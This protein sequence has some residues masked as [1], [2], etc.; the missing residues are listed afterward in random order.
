MPDDDQMPSTS[1]PWRPANIRESFLA[2]V[3]R[4]GSQD[5]PTEIVE[6][7]RTALDMIAQAAPNATNG[8][9]IV[10]NRNILN[11][12]DTVVVVDDDRSSSVSSNAS[13]TRH[14]LTSAGVS[15]NNFERG[16]ADADLESAEE[17]APSPNNTNTN[18]QR[19][20]SRL[21]A[22]AQNRE[23]QRLGALLLNVL[24]FTVIII[25]KL[26]VDGFPSLVMLVLAFSCFHFSNHALV[27]S[28]S[29]FRGKKYLYLLQSNSFVLFFFGVQ[30]LFFGC[31]PLF[32]TMSFITFLPTPITFCSTIH[33]VLLT[34]LAV[35]ILV[36]QLKGLVVAIPSIMLKNKRQRRILQWIE[37]TSQMY[38][39]FLPIPQ[40]MRYFGYSDLNSSIVY[41]CNHF[42]AI[43]Y[44]LYK[45]YLV[46]II[47]RRW[48]ES[49]RYVFH[50]TSVGTIPSRTEIEYGQQ[51][52]ICF[53]DFTSPVKLSCG[54]I[55][56][57]ECI[58][59][60]LDKE[61][62]CPMCRATVAQ[63]DN[64][65]KSGETTYSPQIC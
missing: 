37:Y 41:Y 27:A 32:L 13:N 59:T 55:F 51:C 15:A 52:T 38:R 65:W 10:E 23:L 43:V 6:D 63:E 54:H 18:L 34:D 24:P 42:F 26:L 29:A 9:F 44:F 47:G 4:A 60:W 16:E 8:T 49:T 3:Q 14:R 50:L 48:L 36:V 61:H 35:K 62:T 46:Q 17:N 12:P 28:L 58:G 22:L 19:E 31:E 53:S 20:L 7:L 2:A 57:E 25:V 21:R 11:H 56:C 39:Y 1:V 45:V 64:A 40:W 5:V 33:L 30:F